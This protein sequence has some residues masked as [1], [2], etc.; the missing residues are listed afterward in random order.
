MKLFTLTTVNPNGNVSVDVRLHRDDLASSYHAAMGGWV[1]GVEDV[2]DMDELHT[3]AEDNN[4]RPEIS[5]HDVP[6]DELH[7]VAFGDAFN[8]L[9]LVGPF[10]DYDDALAHAEANNSDY[11]DWHVVAVDTS[12]EN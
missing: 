12:E 7:V 4:F 10:T 1:D 6:T 3:L 8:G 5:E 2:T 9:T 11:G